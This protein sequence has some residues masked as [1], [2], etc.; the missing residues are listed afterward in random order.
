MT[1]LADGSKVS[2]HRNGGAFVVEHNSVEGQLL[3]SMDCDTFAEA[4]AALAYG[5][6]RW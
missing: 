4:Q 5:P 3:D 6:A 2:I 1:Y